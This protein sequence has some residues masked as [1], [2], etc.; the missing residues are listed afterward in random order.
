MRA[1][2]RVCNAANDPRRAFEAPIVAT[3]SNEAMAAYTVRALIVFLSAAARALSR[4]ARTTASS[5]SRVR[6]K[7][8]RPFRE[9]AVVWAVANARDK[10]RLAHWTSHDLRRSAATLMQSKDTRFEVVR[11]VLGH[12]STRNPTD[13]YARHSYDAEAGAAWNWLGS[14]LTEWGKHGQA[15]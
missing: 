6:R 5:F 8:D 11:L 10:R 2:Q 4:N 15:R 7:R 3:A 1:L 12:Y 13:I 14:T 9:H